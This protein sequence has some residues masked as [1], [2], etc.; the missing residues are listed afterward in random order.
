MFKKTLKKSVKI[1]K[2]CS[3]F[4]QRLSKDVEQDREA[5]EDVEEIEKFEDFQKD[6]GKNVQDFLV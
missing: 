4:F 2:N 5:V 6:V 3:R 1:W